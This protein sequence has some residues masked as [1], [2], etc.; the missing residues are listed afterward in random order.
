MNINQPNTSDVKLRREKFAIEIRRSDNDEFFAHQRRRVNG[1]ENSA[2]YVNKERIR[3]IDPE[4]LSLF[5]NNRRHLVE[6]LAKKDVTA[7]MSILRMTREAISTESEVLSAP[8][9]EF[10]QSDIAT[11]ILECFRC[12][13]MLM[14]PQFVQESIWIFSNASAASVEIVDY[15]INLGILNIYSQILPR[16]DIDTTEHILWSL[17]NILGENTSYREIF[18]SYNVLPLAFEA[19]ERFRMYPKIARVAAWL[20]SNAMR[21]PPYPTAN[22]VS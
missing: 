15:L 7:V 1:N 2:K 4:A 13:E 6:F 20:F 11:V 19:I 18:Y 8:F 9:E 10:F 16:A 21:G 17:S 22:L 3:N 12:Q 14:E 5:V